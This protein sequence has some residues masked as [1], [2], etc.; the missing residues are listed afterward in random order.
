MV[1]R[2]GLAFARRFLVREAGLL[3]LGVLNNL[4]VIG[5]FGFI[6]VVA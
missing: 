6:L 5:C 1:K 2:I 4:V 3:F